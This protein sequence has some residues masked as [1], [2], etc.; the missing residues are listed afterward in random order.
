MVAS[1]ARRVTV[2]CLGRSGTVSEPAVNTYIGTI[3]E[4][5]RRWNAYEGATRWFR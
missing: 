5:D 2:R 1:A 4:S 3:A